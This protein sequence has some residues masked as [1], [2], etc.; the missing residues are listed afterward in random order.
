MALEVSLLHTAEHDHS[1]YDS[2]RSLLNNICALEQAKIE[3]GW[4]S[5]LQTPI[6]A[7][8]HMLED[9]ML[10]EQEIVLETSLS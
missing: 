6:S 5:N 10:V 7:S 2:T 3:L 8:F 9:P 4:L 1:I